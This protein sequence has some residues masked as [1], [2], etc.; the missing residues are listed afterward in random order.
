MKKLILISLFVLALL[1]TGCD[2]SSSSDPI[3]D[4]SG[5]GGSGDGN[6]VSDDA[7]NN[8]ITL[9]EGVTVTGLDGT[10]GA[11]DDDPAVLAD[12]NLC[13]MTC[14]QNAGTMTNEEQ[15]NCMIG[16][17][18]VA[19]VVES[20]GV[21]SVA[22]TIANSGSATEDVTINAGTVLA[23][24]S[25]DYQPMMLIQDIDLTIAPGDDTFML[26]V[27]CLAP[28]LS[29]PDSTNSYTISS[30]TTDS[31]L[32]NILAILATKDVDN[33]TFSDSSIVQD[34]IWHCIEDVYDDGYADTAALNAL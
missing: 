27:Y 5:G 33:F 21:F 11:M 6:Y 34:S 13:V 9:P 32:L 14:A 17:L 26:P 20:S 23:P 22:I 2:S 30:V 10:V 12:Y 25:S 24:D 15:M 29:S 28:S 7:L 4:T 16:C 31:C 8:S 18:N 3:G 19:G 1:T